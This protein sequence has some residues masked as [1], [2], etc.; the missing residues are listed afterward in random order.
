LCDPGDLASLII[1]LF[2]VPLV[3]KCG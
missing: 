3:A 2:M 1:L